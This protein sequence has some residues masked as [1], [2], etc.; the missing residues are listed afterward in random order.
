MV[1]NHQASGG[2]CWYCGGMQQAGRALACHGLAGFGL[3][4]AGCVGRHARRAGHAMFL[5]AWRQPAH[6]SLHDARFGLT[7]AGSRCWHAGSTRRASRAAVPVSRC[8]RDGS[9]RDGSRGMAAVE[10]KGGRGRHLNAHLCCACLLAGHGRYCGGSHTTTDRRWL[11]CTDCGILLLK[12]CRVVFSGLPG[13]AASLPPVVLH[14]GPAVSL[15]I[16]VTSFDQCWHPGARTSRDRSVPA[17]SLR[18]RSALLQMPQMRSSATPRAF[19]SSL[20]RY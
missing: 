5:G 10:C 4:L 1:L 17:S 13:S 15:V 11:T 3:E 20:M 9:G 16:A 12:Y 14:L 8:S 18:R 7:Q 19:A 2:L 6:H